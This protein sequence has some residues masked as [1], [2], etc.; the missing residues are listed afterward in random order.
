[1]NM[2]ENESVVSNEIVVD[3]NVYID[4]PGTDGENDTE[5]IEE[6]VTDETVIPED[7]LRNDTV[8]TCTCAEKSLLFQSDI[9]QYN[10]TDG[11]LLL[12]LIVLVIG[13][14]IRRY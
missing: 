7:A 9:L 14:F 13:L 11:L 10:V 4:I 1:M 6:T 12:I 5:V 2:N 3:E 8:I